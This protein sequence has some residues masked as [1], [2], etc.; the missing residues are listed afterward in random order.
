LGEKEVIDKIEKV[1]KDIWR[2]SFE[3]YDIKDYLE[4]IKEKEKI[5]EEIEELG[6]IGRTLGDIAE[7]K[8]IEI[9]KK[10]EEVL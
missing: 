10:L 9:K 3:V 6:E 5:E 8:L 7:I 2:S 4:K 1:S